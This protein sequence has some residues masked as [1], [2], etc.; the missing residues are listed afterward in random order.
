MSKYRPNVALILEDANGRVLVGERLD[1]F[2]AWQ[3]PQGGVKKNETLE[4]AL[5]REMTEE[6]S[7]SS[8]RFE[9]LERKGPYR[10]LFPSGRKKE[11]F[12][13]QEQT[14]FRARLVGGIDGLDGFVHS[15]E[16]RTLCWLAPTE[17]QATWVPEFKRPVYQ[18]V[19][20]DFWGI[21]L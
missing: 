11:G 18:E 10:Y 6:L 21:A 19:F 4:E 2:G 14:Y 12:D 9:V 16:F 17:F 8:D 1:I 15:P 20:R 13:G 5:G 3:F 7:L